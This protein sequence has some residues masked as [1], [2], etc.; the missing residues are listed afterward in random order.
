MR[1]ESAFESLKRDNFLHKILDGSPSKVFKAIRA[2][3]RNHSS[4]INK[5]IVDDKTYLGGNVPDGFYDSLLGL[6]TMNQEKI[7]DPELTKIL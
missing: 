6:K 5:L 4:E 2:A 7:Q 3:K 1:S